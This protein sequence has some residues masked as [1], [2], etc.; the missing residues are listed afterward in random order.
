MGVQVTNNLLWRLDADNYSSDDAI[1]LSLPLSMPY[2]AHTGEYMRVNGDFDYDGH[3]YR[4][5]KQKV[6]HDTL[7]IVCIRDHESM[8]LANALSEYT[9]AANNLPTGTK[10]ALVFLGKLYKDF[11]TTE[12]NVYCQSRLFFERK[13]CASFS[14]ALLTGEHAVESP[15]PWNL[16]ATG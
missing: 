2:P 5:V 3:H 10:Q 9:K 13:F 11:N 16:C 4:L 8:K 12:F 15:P 7:F 1:V 14:P 6:E